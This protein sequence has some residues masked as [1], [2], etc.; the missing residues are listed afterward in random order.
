MIEQEQSPAAIREAW[1]QA[2]VEE[3]AADPRMRDRAIATLL[4]DFLTTA[5]AIQSMA[6]TVK[7]QGLGGLMKMMMSNGR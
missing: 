4:Y 2:R 5:N 7:E 1:I 6:A 3:F